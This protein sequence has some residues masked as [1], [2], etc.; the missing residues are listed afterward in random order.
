MDA[1]ARAPV[2]APKATSCHSALSIG[3]SAVAC[4]AQLFKKECLDF[5]TL[6]PKTPKP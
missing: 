3:S 4:P 6:N 2:P 5:R 1:C